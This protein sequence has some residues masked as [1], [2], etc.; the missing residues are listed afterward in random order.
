MFP[1]SEK[2]KLIFRYFQVRNSRLNSNMCSINQM[3]TE[4]LL[5]HFQKYEDT[6]AGQ[7][8]PVSFHSHPKKQDTCFITGDTDVYRVCSQ[9]CGW[10]TELNA[11]VSKLTCSQWQ[12]T[13]SHNRCTGM[14]NCSHLNNAELVI[15]PITLLSQWQTELRPP[16]PW[17]LDSAC[18]LERSHVL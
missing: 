4:K 9:P 3:S 17:G 12:C 1:V 11:N 6:P 18:Q 14:F 7:D 10:C 13:L 16:I 8:W 15:S 2:K 5:H